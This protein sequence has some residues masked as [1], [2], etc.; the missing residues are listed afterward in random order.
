MP[1]GTDIIEASQ[2]TNKMHE[3]RT[4][5]DVSYRLREIAA[6]QGPNAKLPTTRELCHLL[7]TTP[8]TLIEALND[9]EIQNV[10]YRKPRFGVFVSRRINQKTVAI[11]TGSNVFQGLGAS[12]FWDHLLGQFIRESQRREHDNI[13]SSLFFVVSSRTA[14]EDDTHPVLTRMLEKGQIDG[15]LGLVPGVRFLQLTRRHNVPMVTFAMPG[16]WI[17]LLDKDKMVRAGVGLLTAQGCSRIWLWDPNAVPIQE[18][19]SSDIEHYLREWTRMD[20]V[21]KDMI[22]EHGGRPDESEMHN[23]LEVNAKCESTQQLGYEAALKLLQGPRATWPD[24]ILVTD[25]MMTLGLL[26]AM[27]QLNIRPNVDIRIVSHANKGLP[28]LYLAEGVITQV[29]FDSQVIVDTMYR[30]LDGVFEG[31][32]PEDMHVSVGPSDIV[33]PGEKS[34]AIEDASK[35]TQSRWMEVPLDT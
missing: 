27:S 30:I 21:F 16:D 18:L 23:L 11:V 25:D 6:K 34:L 28:T 19:D 26:R 29:Q 14:G 13:Q 7:Q 4:R 33:L 20:E 22:A 1:R 9:L 5:Q 15:V 32:R 17:V 8:R 31:R 10:V 12:P 35:E 24:G 3:A 2:K